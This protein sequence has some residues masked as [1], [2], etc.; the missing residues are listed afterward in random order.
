M[1]TNPPREELQRILSTYKPGHMLVDQQGRYWVRRAKMCIT[2]YRFINPVGDDQDKFYEQKYI[3]NVPISDDDD[4]VV[5][6]QQSWMQLCILNGLFD[7]HADAM[8]SLQSAL[9]RGFHIDSLRELA[10]LYIEHRFIT[11]D[12]ADTFMAE[13]PTINDSIDEPQ[14]Q[15]TDQLLGNPDSDMGDLLPNRPSFDLSEYQ[16]TFTESQHRAFNWISSRISEGK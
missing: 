8:S 11:A 10:R 12:E 9:S 14:A 4:I 2:R 3:L 5:N 13:I 15:I 16:K 7:E 1:D 6:T